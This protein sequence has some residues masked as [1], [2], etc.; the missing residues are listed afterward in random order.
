MAPR[1]EQQIL[2]FS[3]LTNTSPEEL[4]LFNNSTLQQSNKL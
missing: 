4:G 3:D 2:R 1:L